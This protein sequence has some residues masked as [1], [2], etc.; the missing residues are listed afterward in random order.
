MSPK[1][2]LIYCLVFSA[3][4]GCS[5]FSKKE[6]KVS[7]IEYPAELKKVNAMVI[8]KKFDDARILIDDYL[9][10]S[11]NIHWFGHAYY[12]KGFVYESDNQ[13]DEAIRFYRQAIQHASRYD[14]V[15]EAK[16]IYN[17]SY[18][19]ERTGQMGELSSTLTD[20]MKR[21]QQKTSLRSSETPKRSSYF[22]AR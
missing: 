17:L 14:S 6:K 10:R 3:F 20:L 2:I 7:Y 11:E 13:P 12:L 4:A 5:L 16:A 15:V 8:E 18:V 22:L 1:K 21:P 9:N 19:Y